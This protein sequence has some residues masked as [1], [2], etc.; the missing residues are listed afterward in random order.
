M[1]RKG[2]NL[3]QRLIGIASLLHLIVNKVDRWVFV[4]Y[5]VSYQQL[6]SSWSLSQS[7]ETIHSIRL[8]TVT[9]SFIFYLFILFPKSWLTIVSITVLCFL[10]LLLFNFNFMNFEL[11]VHNSHSPYCRRQ[12]QELNYFNNWS[13]LYDYA[14]SSRDSDNNKI[15]F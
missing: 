5:S 1:H 12:P 10:V 3:P 14:Q 15:S 13:L 2:L 7:K 9:F 4:C 8:C 11:Y 6:C